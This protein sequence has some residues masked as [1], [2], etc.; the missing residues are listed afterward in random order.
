MQPPRPRTIQKKA[1]AAHRCDT[2]FDGTVGYVAL[3][4]IE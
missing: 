1:L 4:G 3:I 2:G